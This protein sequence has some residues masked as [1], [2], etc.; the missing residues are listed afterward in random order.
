LAATSIKTRWAK[1]IIY[2]FSIISDLSILRWSE[3]SEIID[4]KV[5]SR[6]DS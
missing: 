3:T 6:I 1:E 5:P 4:I 2:S